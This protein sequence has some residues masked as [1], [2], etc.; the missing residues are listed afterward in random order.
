VDD[1]ETRRQAL[2]VGGTWWRPR[3]VR[4]VRHPRVLCVHCLLVSSAVDSSANLAA[5]P[6]RR[7][8][9]LIWALAPPLRVFTVAP[10]SRGAIRRP[11]RPRR[12][13]PR[14]S[15]RGPEQWPAQGPLCQR[16]CSEMPCAA[17]TRE[18]PARREGAVATPGPT[19]PPPMTAMPRGASF[20]ATAAAWTSRRHLAAVARVAARPD[21]P[22]PAAAASAAPIHRALCQ[23]KRADVSASATTAAAAAS[24]DAGGAA[25]RVTAAAGA[26]GATGAAEEPAGASAS[27]ASTSISSTRATGGT[28]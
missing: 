3:V 26:A 1:E 21:G 23:R 24:A 17:V 12:R 13:Q 19:A 22:R 10:R 4:K 15:R 11:R 9:H 25:T 5:S 16:R 28:C 20:P 7:C 8:V 18:S 14:V 2:P 27:S 6:L